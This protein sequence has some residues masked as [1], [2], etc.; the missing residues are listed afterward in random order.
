VPSSAYS[1][2]QLDAIRNA[3][4]SGSLTVS[5]DGKSRT[6]RSLDDLIRIEQIVANELGLT[7]LGA[8]PRSRTI[9][10]Q[11][12]SGTLPGGRRGGDPA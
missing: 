9:L 3:I 1:Q 11:F 10:L 6:Y 4:V 8:A 12:D 7:G 5:Y 2:A